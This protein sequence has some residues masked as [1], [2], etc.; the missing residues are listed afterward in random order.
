MTTPDANYKKIYRLNA[1]ASTGTTFLSQATG[2]TT[3]VVITEVTT[4]N[5]EVAV[6]DDIVRTF[7]LAVTNGTT[8]NETISTDPITQTFVGPRVRI[9]GVYV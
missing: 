3:G 1:T 8:V 2:P 6:P 4:K 5:Y 9:A 7:N